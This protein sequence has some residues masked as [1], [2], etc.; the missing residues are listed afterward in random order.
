MRNDVL[1]VWEVL[2]GSTVGLLAATLGRLY[3][4]AFWAL[5]DT[6]TPLRF[7]IVRVLLTTGLGWFLAFPVPRWLGIPA[8]LGLVGLTISAGMA[9]WVEFTLLRMA[10][11]RKIGRTGLSVSYTLKLWA[12]AAGA[13]VSAF[14]LKMWLTALPPLLSGGVVLPLYGAAYF[15]FAAALRVPEATRIVKAAA[16][17]AKLDK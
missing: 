11:N 1:Y 16:D 14:G 3:T 6:R 4:S 10:L 15:G 12:A 5:R 9:A 7:A 8:S 13:A 17:L 2:A